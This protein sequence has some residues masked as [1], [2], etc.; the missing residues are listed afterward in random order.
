M[1][2]IEHIKERIEDKEFSE[3]VENY[4]F[5]RKEFVR[6]Y[7]VGITFSGVDFSQCSFNSCYFRNC[8]FIRC[9]FTGSSFKESYLR[10]STFPESIFKY[11]TFEKSPMDDRFLDAALPAEENLARD[12]V[13]SLRVNFSQIGNYE[14]V[15]KASAIEV[16]LTG[17]HL[18]KAA[19][20]REAYYRGKEHYS[21]WK[22]VNFIAHHA[23]WKFLDLLWGNGES[24]R[25][26]IVSSNLFILFIAA[27]NWL[28]NPISILKSTELSFYQFLGIVTCNDV[29]HTYVALLTI[30][31]LIFFSLFI[32]ILIKRLSKR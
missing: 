6:V 28:E 27:L 20:S 13:R 3:H 32:S 2:L 8:R 25:R 12:L 11:T 1:S 29:S 15:N 5:T 10:G 4:S 26:V 14:A 30:G 19:Y 24:L 23:Q 18:Y 16:Q 31:R 17:A 7:A 9:N 21:G 22:R